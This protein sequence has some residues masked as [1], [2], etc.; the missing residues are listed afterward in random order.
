VRRL[1]CVLVLLAARVRRLV[2]LAY[3][4]GFDVRAVRAG[5]VR[6]SPLTLRG[7]GRASITLTRR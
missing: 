6:R 5:A 7:A 4:R 3:P 2:R 1:L